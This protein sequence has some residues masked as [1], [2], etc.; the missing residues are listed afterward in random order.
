MKKIKWWEWDIGEPLGY[1][2][3]L[4]FL[5]VWGLVFNFYPLLDWFGLS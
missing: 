4:I 3:G 2:I 1:V 5:F